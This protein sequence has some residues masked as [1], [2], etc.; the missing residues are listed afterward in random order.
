MNNLYRGTAIYASYPVS[1]HLAKWFQRYFEIDQPETIT[2]YG[3]SVSG[4]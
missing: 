3:Y 2:A 4:V 1:I